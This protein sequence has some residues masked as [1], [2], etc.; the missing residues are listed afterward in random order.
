MSPWVGRAE[1]GDRPVIGFLLSKVKRTRG[2]VPSNVSRVLSSLV[3]RGG[4]L[5]NVHLGHFSTQNRILSV[6]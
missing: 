2:P 1:T 6:K 3:A 4:P 5:I